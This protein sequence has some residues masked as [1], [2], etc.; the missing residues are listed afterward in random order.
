MKVYAIHTGCKYEGG[1]T[2]E[3]Y[4]DKEN[5]IKFASMLVEEFK[6]RDARIWTWEEIPGG[7]EEISAHDEI[8]KAWQSPLDEIV[9]YEYELK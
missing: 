8:I 3:I 4:A 9:V 6:K 2:R 7:W 5:A 1:I